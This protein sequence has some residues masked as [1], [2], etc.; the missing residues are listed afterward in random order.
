LKPAKERLITLF[1]LILTI[2]GPVALSIYI[3][4]PGVELPVK[5]T[6]L[7]YSDILNGLFN[8]IF[9]PAMDKIGER[10]FSTEKYYGFKNGSYKC[11]IPYVDYKFEYPLFT[12]LLWYISTCTAFKY[13]TSIDEAALIHYYIQSAFI[14]LFYVLLVYSLY[15]ILRDILRIKPLRLLIL[16]LP[17]TIVYMVYSWDIIAASLA[18]LGTLLIIKGGRDRVQPLLAGLLHGLSISTKILTAGIVYYY[19]V[20]YVSI[21]ESK[22]HEFVLYAIG[23]VIIGVLPFLL[24]YWYATQGFNYLVNHHLSWYCENCL[25]MP[26]VKD[27]WDSIHRR[28]FISIATALAIV[29]PLIAAPWRG[30]D[31]T[32]EF[33]Y[34]LAATFSLILFNHV[35]S[36]QMIL[37]ITPFAIIG[38]ESRF[39]VLYGVA[40]VFN[41]LIITT[42]FEYSNPW[43]FGSIPQY[44]AFGRNITLL[45]LFIYVVGSIL[46]DKIK[47][48]DRLKGRST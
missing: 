29:F 26:L 34:L 41:A 7:K 6:G 30:I 43:A 11:P 39:L 35:F 8:P 14:A 42:F 2:L 17:S 25:Y 16:L 45:L 10:W 21:R 3:H 20:K 31:H 9:N 4:M 19:I 23:V 37:M 12:G 44:M 15:L 32:V 13:S 5:Y 22:V 38:L 48:V 28:L 1:I 18:V 33:K 47:Y 40:D 24:L 46:K 27:I 36:P